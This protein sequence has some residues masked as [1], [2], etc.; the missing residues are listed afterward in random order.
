MKRFLEI[1]MVLLLSLSVNNVIVAQGKAKIVFEQT[2]HNFGSFKESDGVQSTTF[3]FKNE[4][5]V[6]LVLNNV[7]PSC[8]CTTPKWSREPIAPG[9]SGDRCTATAEAGVLAS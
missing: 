7:R 8:G 9:A 6:P 5:A 2:E 3:K 1:F 4:G